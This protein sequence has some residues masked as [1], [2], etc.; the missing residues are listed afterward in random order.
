MIEEPLSGGNAGGPV[1]R[2]GGTVRK[3]WTP[4]SSSVARFVGAIRAAG[5]DAPAFLGRDARGRQVLEFVPG[6]LAMQRRLSRVELRRVGAM[7]RA[8]H[9]ASAAFERLPDDTWETAITAPGDEIVCHNDLATWNLITGERWVFIDWDAAAPSTR[10][11]D[12]A[13]A[14]Q[15]FTLSDPSRSVQQAAQDLAAFVDG[16]RADAVIRSWLPAALSERTHAMY[17][18]LRSSHESGLEPWASMFAD[19][20][21]A[22]WD[23]A[24]RFVELH[25]DHWA[26]AL[27]RRA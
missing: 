15:A 2:V 9:D 12:L 17:R 16:Y 7:V 20:H 14:A 18:L 6:E 5:V 19:G 27:S 24:A 11:W 4:S 23:R 1:V 10:L 26:S 25:R 8:I 3:A 21:G 13:Y 22:H